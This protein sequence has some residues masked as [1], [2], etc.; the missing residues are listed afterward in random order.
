[1]TIITLEDILT[2]FI[3]VYLMLSNS[4]LID[5]LLLELKLSEI[6]DVSLRQ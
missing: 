4:D 5:E 3:E 2:Y 1:M 6:T